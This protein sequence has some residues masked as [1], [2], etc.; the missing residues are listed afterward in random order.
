MTD[1]ESFLAANNLSHVLQLLQAGG[2]STLSSLESKLEAGRAGFLTHL[3]TIGL[4][5]LK[6]RQGLTNAL[7]KLKRERE[8]G[9]G[10]A[11]GGLTRPRPN[12]TQKTSRSTWAQTMTAIYLDVSAVPTRGQASARASCGPRA[13]TRTT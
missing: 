7:A 6:D 5:A 12:S 1:L 10:A 13:R 8:S 3:K 11:A 2:E 4:T 9:G